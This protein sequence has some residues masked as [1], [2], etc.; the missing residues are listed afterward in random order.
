MSFLKNIIENVNHHRNIWKKKKYKAKNESNEKTI[1]WAIIG[2]GSMANTFAQALSISPGANIVAVAS[3]SKKKADLFA[4]KYN[5]F[6]AFESYEKMLKDELLSIDIVYIATPVFCHYENIKLA[7]LNNKNVLCEKPICLRA[8]ELLEL[9]E[10]ATQ[11]KLFLSEGMWM[12]YLPVFKL[13]KQWISQ[14]KI[15]QVKSIRVDF[16]KREFI[17]YSNYKYSA[18]E[19]S[20]V[21]LDYGVYALAFVLNFMKLPINISNCNSLKHKKGFDKDWVIILN[22]TQCF[23]AITISYDFDGC[24]KAVLFGEN[25]TIEWYSQFNRTNTI[26][27]INSEGVIT[28]S[29]S[30]K[31]KAS[32]FEFEIDEIQTCLRNN[33]KETDIVPLSFSMKVLDIIASIKN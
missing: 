8:E 31:Y 19:G 25:G 18:S 7:L 29:S 12:L 14:G 26:K 4:K 15:G 10:L 9:R 32:G 6:K 17:D 11:R 22:D 28:D 21:L 23:S 16:S 30:F 24:R 27:C 13:A 3:R 1:N 20:G 33:K 2:L 5:I